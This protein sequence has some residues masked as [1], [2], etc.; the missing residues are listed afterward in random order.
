[1]SHISWENSQN[2][3]SDGP[4]NIVYVLFYKKGLMENRAEMIIVL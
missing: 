4:I 1:M 2:L 3:I